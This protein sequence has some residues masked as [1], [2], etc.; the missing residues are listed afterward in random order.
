[1]VGALVRL[2]RDGTPRAALTLTDGTGRYQLGAPGAGR[3]ALVVERIGYATTT[4][5]AVDVPATGSVVVDAFVETRAVSLEGLAVEGDDRRCDLVADAAV[6]TQRMWDEARKALE[7]AA[8]TEQQGNL[9]FRIRSREATLDPR[10][11]AARDEQRSVRMEVGGN[12][13]RSLPAADLVANGY[14][15]AGA[16]GSVDYYAPDAGALMSDEFLTTHC[17]DLAAG[18]EEEPGLV[19]LRFRP[20]PGRRVADIEGIL[21]IART[22][23]RLDRLDFEYTN[24][25]SGPGSKLANGAIRFAELSDGRWIVSDWFIRAPIVGV[26][27]TSGLN[28]TVQRQMA[29]GVAERGSEV[30]SASGQGVDWVADRPAGAVE[31]MVHDSLSGGPLARAEVRLAGRSWRTYTDAEGRYRFEGVP[32]GRFRVEFSHARLDSLGVDPGWREAEVRAG[33]VTWVE[34]AVPSRASIVAATC[35]DDRGAVI[36]GRVLDR[37][38]GDAVPGAQVVAVGATAPDG[39]PLRA[40]TDID[41]WYRLC[42]VPADTPLTLAA[43]VGALASAMTDV[44]PE[45]EGRVRADLHMDLSRRPVET[46]AREPGQTQLAGTVMDVQTSRALP[47]VVV[48]LVEAGGAV[49]RQALSDAQGRFVLRPL[50]EG[51]YA[52]ATRALGYAPIVGGA[53]EVRPGRNQIEVQLSPEAIAVE[54]VVVSVEA[55]APQLELNGFYD[56]RFLSGGQFIEQPE[57]EAMA[58]SRAT[59]VLLRVPGVQLVTFTG[60]DTNTTLRRIRLRGA[61]SFAKE[62]SCLPGVYIDGVLAASPVIPR[63]GGLDASPPIDDLVA[64]QDIEAIE[65]YDTP[66]VTPA[67]FQA[68]GPPCGMLV[69]WTRF[70][71][72]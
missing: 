41:G 66:A 24:L 58:P 53:L 35:A 12:T 28:G 60:E 43:R 72:R 8:W 31:G 6:Q 22:S 14:V 26:V 65:V 70:G 18:S 68:P 62:Q 5:D 7:V 4:M 39:Q 54:G 32:P 38:S 27:R 64:W 30:L 56:R 50:T 46:T 47:D 59:D 44:T 17:L 34:L 15:R 29:T 55:R 1:V 71:G 20:L 23:G 67:R 52:V 63:R 2:A 33:E 51:T 42:G 3:Y 21:W 49:V 37:D 25:P 36:V 57:I 40:G 61:V 11:L 10:S 45:G 9:R 13:V 48:Q 69:I 19:G 16:G